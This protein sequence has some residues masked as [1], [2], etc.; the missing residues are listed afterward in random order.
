MEPVPLQSPSALTADVAA[1]PNIVPSN[2]VETSWHGSLSAGKNW[3]FPRLVASSVKAARPGYEA[4]TATEYLDS[5]DVLKEKVA[6]LAKLLRQHGSAGGVVVYT[7]AGI[8]T[9]AGVPDYASRAS[10]SRAPHMRSGLSSSNRL[11]LMPTFCHKAVAALEQKGLVQHWL[12]QN[13]DRLAQKAGFPQAKL[14]EIHGAWGDVKNSVLMMDD[15]LRPDLLDWLEA[16]CHRATLVLAI[17]TSLCGMTSDCVA[18]AVADRADGLVIVNLQRTRL[19]EESCLRI[20]GLA[21]D[22]M[23]LLCKELGSPVPHPEAKR[24]GEDWVL[25]HPS[26]KFGTPRRTPKD[27]I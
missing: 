4:F 25:Q 5:E 16:W 15:R 19:D 20:W 11:L 7:G 1:E 21:D 2:S 6:L 12:Q 13:H 24:R 22:V 18:T 3:E 26:C 27:P 17:G 8:S 9:A 10:Q 14:N 23:K